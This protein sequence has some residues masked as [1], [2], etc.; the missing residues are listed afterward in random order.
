MKSIAGA[1]ALIL[2]AFLPG[3]AYADGGVCPR[4]AA[5]SDVAQ[6]ADL[7]SE[8]GVLNVTLNYYTSVDSLART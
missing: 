3:T 5:G 1:A 6:P 7:Y 8:N 4:P 2:C